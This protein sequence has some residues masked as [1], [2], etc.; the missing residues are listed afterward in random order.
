MSS[1]HSRRLTRTTETW[2]VLIRC[3]LASN[4]RR[5]PGSRHSTGTRTSCCSLKQI[6]D[7]NKY[8]PFATRFGYS[9]VLMIVLSQ[10]FCEMFQWKKWKFVEKWPSYRYGLVYY[11]F[12]TQCIFTATGSSLWHSRSPEISCSCHINSS[13]YSCGATT[14]RRSLK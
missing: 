13:S 6:H 2:E 12:E 11:L 7:I 8:I 10:I 4:R 9:D 5:L 3:Y 14:D 1:L